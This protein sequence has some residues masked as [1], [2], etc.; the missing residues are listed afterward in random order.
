LFHFFP[1]CWVLLIIGV[2]QGFIMAIFPCCYHSKK[3]HIL[4]R[5]IFDYTK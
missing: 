4:E 2:C 5:T 3:L 1:V